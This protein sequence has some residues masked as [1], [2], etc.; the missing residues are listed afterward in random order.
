[1]SAELWNNDAE[2]ELL[3][4]VERQIERHTRADRDGPHLEN[5]PQSR[6]D[7]KKT[8]TDIALLIEK[9]TPE[10]TCPALL[11]I[12]RRLENTPDGD[13]V[14]ERGV[15]IGV[16]LQQGLE[17]ARKPVLLPSPNPFRGM[18]L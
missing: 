12:A 11:T 7:F 3:D 9:Q 5:S 18:R 15:R 4:R 14:N 16:V 8:A 17:E 6:A 2:K 10:K 1:M 13:W